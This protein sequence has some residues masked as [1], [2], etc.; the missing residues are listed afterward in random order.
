MPR[1]ARFQEPPLFFVP[2]VPHGNERYHAPQENDCLH[3]ETSA[4]SAH[5][6]RPLFTEIAEKLPKEKPQ[7]SAEKKLGNLIIP[8]KKQPQ[9]NDGCC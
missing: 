8:P 1:Y 2:F 4:K 9:Q 7:E 6:V 3:F 5:G